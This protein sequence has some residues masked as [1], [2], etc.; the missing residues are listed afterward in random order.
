[1][2]AEGT[3]HPTKPPEKPQVSSPGGAKSGA[4]DPELVQVSR[5]WRRL[6]ASARSAILAL[7]QA[8]AKSNG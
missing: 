3:E 1:M 2:G 6:P 7:A 8:A 4:V 5:L